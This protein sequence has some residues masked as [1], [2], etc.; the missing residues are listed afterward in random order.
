MSSRKRA[1]QSRIPLP[2]E[3]LRPSVTRRRRILTQQREV[4]WQ[5]FISREFFTAQQLHELLLR[6][7][8]AIDLTAVYR[9]LNFFCNTGIAKAFRFGKRA[10]FT[11][12]LQSNSGGYLI[13]T[14]CGH[15]QVFNN[16]NIRRLFGEVARQNQF[17][18]KTAKYEVHGLCASCGKRA[19]R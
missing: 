18:M 8:Q 3:R 13:C 10:V 19:R 2:L 1:E 5:N 9:S 6:K 17:M 4:I 14:F 12:V 15:V 16:L 7:N 11:N